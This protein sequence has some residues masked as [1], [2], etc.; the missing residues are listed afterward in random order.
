MNVID[1]NKNIATLS[2]ISKSSN[3]VEVSKSNI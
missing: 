2:K 1:V 3:K